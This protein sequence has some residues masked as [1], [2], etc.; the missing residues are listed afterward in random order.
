MCRRCVDRRRGGSPWPS[1]PSAGQ[2]YF[3]PEC[4]PPTPSSGSRP[5]R[6]RSPAACS[7]RTARPT[8]RAVARCWGRCRARWWPPPSPCSTPTRS[9]RPSSSGGPGSTRRPSAPPGPPGAV[10]QLVRVLGA[11]PEGLGRATGAVGARRWR[12]CGPRASRCSPGSSSL[13][14]P[15]DPMGDMWRLA[16]LLREYRGDAHTAAWTSAGLDATEVGLLT[17][18]YWG[19]PM[20]SYIRTRAWSDAQLDEAEGR[21][22]GTWP[23]GRRRAHRCR[24]GAAGVGRGGHRRPVRGDGGRARRP[25]RR[26]DGVDDSVGRGRCATPAATRRRARTTWRRRADPHAQASGRCSVPAPGVMKRASPARGPGWCA[27]RC[28]GSPSPPRPELHDAPP[29][30]D[31]LNHVDPA[32]EEDDHLVARRVPLPGVPC[33]LLGGARRPAAPRRR[34]LRSAPRRR[35]GT[36]GDQAKS[37]KRRRGGPEPRWTNVCARSNAAPLM[38]T[39]ATTVDRPH[40]GS[41]PRTAQYSGDHSALRRSRLSQRSR[42]VEG[43][44]HPG[45]RRGGRGREV[46]ASR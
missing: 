26:A 23:R 42:T 44:V 11:E 36:R 20:R 10:A 22:V 21:L 31:L 33:A 45:A 34:R 6:G 46:V 14:L 25:L 7:C 28:A 16:D 41:D 18:L 32:R 9:C 43:V 2:V 4:Q 19:L 12:R 5:A 17:E 8:S 30:L 1:S 3:S 35:R 15:G 13:G 24:T 37:G 39:P 40:V 27:R 38:G 29:A